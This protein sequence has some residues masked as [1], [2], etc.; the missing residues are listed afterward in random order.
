MGTF[1]PEAAVRAW[2][3][4][5][6][7]G[8]G[9][10]SAPGLFPSSFHRWKVFTSFPNSPVSNCCVFSLYI[11]SVV[12]FRS[13]PRAGGMEARTCS[14]LFLLCPVNAVRSVS[15]ARGSDPQGPT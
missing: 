10:L 14:A 1:S 6:A 7:P 9:R 4:S 13:A 12:N 15:L 11:L 2:P 3:Q 8:P 5:C